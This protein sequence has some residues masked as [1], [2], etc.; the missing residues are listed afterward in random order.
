MPQPEVH[1]LVGALF[2]FAVFIVGFLIDKK[3]K[4]GFSL[5]LPI[6]ILLFGFAASVP[7]LPS[8]M[9]YYS[10]GQVGKEITHSN[11]IDNIFFLHIWL[12]NYFGLGQ[13]GPVILSFIGI[14]FIYCIVFLCY[15]YAF[16]KEIFKK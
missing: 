2:A 9:E 13:Q 11:P 3:V 7:D 10:M 12:D 6:L 14:V 16:N 5:Y 4:K 1:F 8:A 15:I